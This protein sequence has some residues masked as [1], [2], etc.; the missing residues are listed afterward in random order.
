MYLFQ[1][2]S[3]EEEVEMSLL[4]RKFLKNPLVKLSSTEQMH[5]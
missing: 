5:W 1:L 3:R 4:E 2:L